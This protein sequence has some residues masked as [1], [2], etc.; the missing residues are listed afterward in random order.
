MKI[1]KI[2]SRS[3]IAGRL[4]LYAYRAGFTVHPETDGTVKLFAIRANYYVFRGSKDRAVSFV[5]D[6]LSL[7]SRLNF[8]S[9]PV[10]I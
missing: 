7:Q 10:S 5:M 3:T 6:E 4:N 2:P 8:K 1:K 9:S